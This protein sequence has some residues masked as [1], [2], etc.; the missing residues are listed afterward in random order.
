MEIKPYIEIEDLEGQPIPITETKAICP[1]CNKQI[2]F[3]AELGG[4]V[5]KTNKNVT[6]KT[7]CINSLMS[8][9]EDEKNLSGEEK[10][11]RGLLAERI[12]TAKK[13]VDLTVE[14][15]KLLKDLI[16]K[17]P[18][19]NPLYIMRAYELLDPVKKETAKKEAK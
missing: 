6:L 16:G 7:I 11:K 12:Y 18:Q 8:G 17:N 9:Y 1:H 3:N 2:P 10:L 15:L 13:I 4:I 5:I 19:Y 14:E